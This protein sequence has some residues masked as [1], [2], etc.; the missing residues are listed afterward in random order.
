M[1]RRLLS[2]CCS[3]RFNPSRQRLRSSIYYGVVERMTWLMI[4][5]SL[6]RDGPSGTEC[7]LR[8]QDATLQYR[9][10]TCLSCLYFQAMNTCKRLQNATLQL[11]A[12]VGRQRASCQ[13]KKQ[14]NYR[15]GGEGRPGRK[16]ISSTKYCH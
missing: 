9:G 1:S 16:N 5:F 13:K 3:K 2:L 15:V 12:F 6:G 4:H 8:L 11:T 10:F 14:K 7:A